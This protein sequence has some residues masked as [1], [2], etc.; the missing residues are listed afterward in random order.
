MEH[1]IANELRMA[2]KVLSPPLWRAWLDEFRRRQ[3][4]EQW[5]RA[6]DIFTVH[7]GTAE[8]ERVYLYQHQKIDIVSYARR[9]GL[10]WPL[11]PIEALRTEHSKLVPKLHPWISRRSDER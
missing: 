7:R 3:S 5:H 1:I 6:W 11:P 2:Y 4:V 8:V 10:S 9:F